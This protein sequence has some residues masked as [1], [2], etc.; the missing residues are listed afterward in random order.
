MSTK[1]TYQQEF[2]VAFAEQVQD[3]S[4]STEF[5]IDW[6]EDSVEFPVLSSSAAINDGNYTS[7]NWELLQRKDIFEEEGLHVLVPAEEEEEW[8]KLNAIEKEEL[9]SKIIEK[10]AQELQPK[11]YTITPLWSNITKESHV[12]ADDED[13]EYVDENDDNNLGVE[14]IDTK[15]SQSRRTSRLS[16]RRKIHDLKA[17]DIHV[18]GIYSIATQKRG[19][20]SSSG[21]NVIGFGGYANR[22]DKANALALCSQYSHSMKKRTFKYLGSSNKKISQNEISEYNVHSKITEKNI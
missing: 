18:R 15:K 22:S 19:Q 14:L 16:N 21:D 6:L 17:V 8:S 3:P 4:A 5:Y 13:E 7:G 11:Q 20:S 1:L 10:N 2:P 9:Y 12:V